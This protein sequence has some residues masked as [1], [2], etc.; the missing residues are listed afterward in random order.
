MVMDQV[1]RQV[2]R[3]VGKGFL[4]IVLFLSTYLLTY[5]PTFIN[6][7]SAQQACTCFCAVEGQG[8]IESGN[9][10]E[11]ACSDFCQDQYASPMAVCA[12]SIE[13]GP[14][15]NLYC[16]DETACLNQDGVL[17][18]KQASECIPGTTYCYPASSLSTPL[19][20]SIGGASE[21]DDLGSYIG[22]IYNWMVGIGTLIAIIFIMIG[23]LQWAFGGVSAQSIGKAKERMKNA[24]TGLVLLLSSYLILFTVN[25]QLLSPKMPQLPM[26]RQ[27][28]LLSE[29][30]CGY[31]TNV[32][33]P[34]T[35]QV[36]NG[37]PKNSPYAASPWTVDIASQTNTEWC[38]SIAEVLTDNEGR[39]VASGT[40]CTYDYCEEKN[41]R[42][43]G[44][45]T[46]YDCVKC[47]DIVPDGAGVL[48]PSDTVC[49]QLSVGSGQ[50]FVTTGKFDQCFYSTDP[51]LVVS[52]W[53]K[54]LLTIPAFTGVATVGLTDDVAQAIGTGTCS[55]IQF[56]CA[57]I[58]TCDD[59]DSI[60]IKNANVDEPLED[61]VPGTF[62]SSE[63]DLK[64][65]C[66]DDP[67]RVQEETGGERC[68]FSES[69]GG[70]AAGCNEA[71]S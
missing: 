1:G 25:P 41:E 22:L 40:T 44:S 33:G 54:V 50:S 2:S 26:V 43:A 16:F 64:S 8:A 69:I 52:E 36:S 49:K 18:D 37:A 67:C 38:G 9:L 32:W 12:K 53:E 48:T 17:S 71:D 5:S 6:N 19:S 46:N 66:E 58:K 45:G 65:I 70:L 20:V 21:V 59:Y 29:G 51:N 13:D 23:G 7:V 61:I 57:Q 62:W 10:T 24:V 11:S 68:V 30:S 47:E 4:I 34:T 60:K 55:R 63:Y 3:L 15:T 56:N 28:A 27:V 35:Y 42:C 31:L 14:S 39:K